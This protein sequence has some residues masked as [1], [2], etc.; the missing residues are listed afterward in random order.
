M[1][2]FIFSLADAHDGW[3]GET[4]Q[5][6]DVQA[7]KCVAIKLI[8]DTLC[9]HP[10]AF[11]D[12]ESHQVTVSDERRLTLFIIDI[13]A[14]TSPAMRYEKRARASDPGPGAGVAATGGNIDRAA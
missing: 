6:P 1:P 14:T 7:A 2:G 3:D 13:S 9:N 8:A 11:W 10:Q 5:L 12:A 4:V